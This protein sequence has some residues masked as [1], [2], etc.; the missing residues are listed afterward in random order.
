MNALFR[1]V[2]LWNWMELRVHCHHDYWMNS[3]QSSPN[4]LGMVN[5]VIGQG[6]RSFMTQQPITLQNR[7][8]RLV[9]LLSLRLYCEKTEIFLKNMMWLVSVISVIYYLEIYKFCS[10]RKFCFVFIWLHFHRLLFCHF[11]SFIYSDPYFLSFCPIFSWT[12]LLYSKFH[13]FHCSCR[14]QSTLIRLKWIITKDRS[15][16]N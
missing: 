5:G 4:T 10:N 11:Y 9:F 3:L 16:N 14:S 13:V 12:D 15:Y 7:Q 2:L 8:V 6:S 1:L